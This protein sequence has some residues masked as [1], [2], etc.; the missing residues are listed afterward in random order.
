MS[1]YVRNPTR[2]FE[3]DGDS[4]TA[5]LKPLSQL[6]LASLGDAASRVDEVRTM[7]DVVERNVV[8]LSGIADADGKEIDVATIA[9]EAYF[10][11]LAADIF[12]AL[13]EVSQ[14]ANP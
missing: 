3:F 11:Q 1:R 8:S 14:P 9:R 2:T 13:V 6:E 12:K 7:G 4:I 10:V 5:V